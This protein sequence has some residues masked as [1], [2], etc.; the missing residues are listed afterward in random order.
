MKIKPRILVVDNDPASAKLLEELLTPEGYEVVTASDG[1]EALKQVSKGQIDLVILDTLMPE[2]DVFKVT[3]KLKADEETR[4]IPVLLLSALNDEQTRAKGIEAGCDDFI[5]K[6]FDH[7][8][9]LSTI[10]TLLQI[11][12]YRPLINARENLDYLL[13]YIDTGIVV[14]GNAL[15]VIHL[16]K[17]AKELLLPDTDELPANLIDHIYERFK[18][19]YAG[20]LKN[21]ILSGEFSFDMERL[22]TAGAGALVLVVRITT[23]RNPLGEI[24][25]TV[26]TLNDVTEERREESL[27]QEFLSLISHK[28]RTPITVITQGASMLEEGI[29]G[30]LTDKQKKISSAIMEKSLMLEALVDK[31]LGFTTINW[32]KTDPSTEAIDL[33]SY[34]PEAVDTAI[35]LVKNKKVDLNIDCPGE[36]VE[37]NINRDYLDLM[38]GNLVDNAIKF[39]DK[40]TVKIDI[41]VKN[42]RDE[43][44]LS[45]AD[46]GPGIPDSE[47][48]NVF[49]KFY[50]VEKHFTG[51]VEGAG[52]GLAIVKQLAAAHGGKVELGSARGRG[53]VF[54]LTLKR[55]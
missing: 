29:L 9:V 18:V 24:C 31:L 12:R 28:F 32:E 14:L 39:N 11:S 22:Q 50:Q 21:A 15:E 38:V 48:E 35:K 52:L 6:P 16:N 49:K 5:S 55:G 25:S 19:N 47:K 45:V 36:N 7:N 23:V 53:S 34:L 40:E 51:N 41:S 4:L 54:T 37:I 20:D 33:K 13:N 43:I 3:K 8:E 26:M 1:N 17:K 44:Q 2:P 27:K 42:V 30:P 46:N 10:F